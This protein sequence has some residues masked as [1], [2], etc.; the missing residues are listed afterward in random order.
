MDQ[1][2]IRQ[3]GDIVY[4]GLAV[5]WLVIGVLMQMFWTTLQP[6]MMIP[7][8]RSVMGFIC[9]IL[10]SY[11]F[12]RWRMM[13]GWGYRQP[14]KSDLPPRPRRVDE[15]IDPNFDFSDAADPKKPPPSAP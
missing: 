12:V 15:P 8:D 10:F 1:R 9:F 5:F 14:E 3:G 6:R 4:L 11:S 2:F 7:V 13:S